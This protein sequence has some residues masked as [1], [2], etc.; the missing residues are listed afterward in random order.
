MLRRLAPCQQ[1]A[2]HSRP[3]LG[4]CP[5]CR[6]L[7]ASP[8]FEGCGATTPA[9]AGRHRALCAGGPAVI[10]EILPRSVVAEHAHGDLLI[11]NLPPDEEALVARAVASR[12]GEFATP[13][14]CAR[15]ALPRLGAATGPI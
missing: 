3:P 10:T 1:A 14:N 2:A 8:R 5:G 9:A 4:P 6:R 13:R 11:A 12:R 15:R 7:P